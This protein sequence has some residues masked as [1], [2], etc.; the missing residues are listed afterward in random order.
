MV[1]SA[2]IGIAVA[3]G[4]GGTAEGLLRSAEI[5]MFR[6][7]GSG[8]G[9]W[10]LHDPANSDSGPV[11]NRLR[12]IGELR[13]GIRAGEL[14]LHY[15]PRVELRTGHLQ[16]VEA[17]VRWQHPK[18]GLLRPDDFMEA[19]EGSGLIHALGAWVLETAIAQAARWP[20]AGSTGRPVEM[21]VNLSTRQLSDPHLAEVV[22]D[23]LRRHG[24]APSTLTLE[25]TETALMQDPD[26][27]LDTL[28]ALH[29]LG[30]NLAV[31]DFG[32]GYASLTYLQQFPIDEIK[33]DRSFVNGLA[34]DKADSTIV[35]TCIQLAHAMGIRALAEGVETEAQ[36]LALLALDCDQ[37]Q[38]YLYSPPLAAND[39]TDWMSK[40][41]HDQAPT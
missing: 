38:G 25:L 24:V 1:I 9:C 33:I 4:E 18:R 26:A 41:L 5:A 16:G 3:V 8:R 23:A 17:L 27:A 40:R 20:A 35:A 7:K 10:A 13:R 15:Q 32:T 19:A 34:A 6:A 11:V 30:V 28:T 31:D 21:A 36:R 22:T 2:S 14:R 29:G 39:L 37:A 12:V